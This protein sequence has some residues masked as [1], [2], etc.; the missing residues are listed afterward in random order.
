MIDERKIL[1]LLDNTP[2]FR[3]IPHKFLAPVFKQSM[4]ISLDKGER[5]L[6][7]GIINEHVYI[8]ISGQLSVHLTQSN[9]DEPI[10]ILNPGECVGE[11]SV[12]VDRSVSAYVTANTDCKLLAIGYSSFWSL[13]KG[14][15][16]AALNMLNILVQRIRTGNEAIADTLLH[17]DKT[18]D[19]TVVIDSLTG[20]YNQH[21]IQGKFERM[22]HLSSVGKQAV[23]LVLLQVDEAKSTPVSVSELSDDE[24]I[25]SIAQTILTILRPG[26]CAARL[27]GKQF[28]ILLSNLQLADAFAMAERLR[29]TV[30]QL[31][32]LLPD[33]S[34]LPP[35]TISGGLSKAS[36]D[37]TWSKLLAKAKDALEQAINAG[38][39]R[40]SD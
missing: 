40:I 27:N 24:S 31:R 34:S 25:H 15:N 23:C 3:G 39:N 30:C 32:I 37:D 11:M 28:A 13:I 36:E 14:S 6:T 10:A 17:H 38:R 9:L 21:G 4:Q 18:P 26:D 8:L 20:L 7:P 16:D 1:E 33:G 19:T 22:L 2:L 35:V 29:A 12:L 5:L